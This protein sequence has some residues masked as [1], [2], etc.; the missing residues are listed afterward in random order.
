MF[1]SQTTDFRSNIES[2][3]LRLKSGKRVVLGANSAQF[4]D[5]TE[6]Q[7]DS[8]VLCTGFKQTFQNILPVEQEFWPLYLAFFN[9]EDPTLCFGGTVDGPFMFLL[10]ERNSI[11]FKHVLNGTVTLPSKE[12]MLESYNLDLQ[13]C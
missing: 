11:F 8:I 12:K 1:I 4:E 10:A 2:G 3:Q 6:E 5:G 7:I 13:T 9:I